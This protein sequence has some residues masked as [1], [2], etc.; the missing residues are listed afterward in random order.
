MKLHRQK[1]ELIICRLIYISPML[2]LFLLAKRGVD[3]NMSFFICPKIDVRWKVECFENLSCS[4]SVKCLKASLFPGHATSNVPWIQCNDFF[5][6]RWHYIFATVIQSYVSHRKSFLL[7]TQ[8]FKH[9]VFVRRQG[10]HQQWFWRERMVSLHNL[11]A[12]PYERMGLLK[13]EKVVEEI[14]RN[15][16]YG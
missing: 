14:S 13:C 15:W 3:K 5:D 12:A 11:E 16:H 2:T 6:V 1:E 10:D 9:G 8:S 4:P 7:V